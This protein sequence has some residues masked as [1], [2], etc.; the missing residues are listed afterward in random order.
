MSMLDAIDLVSKGNLM[1]RIELAFDPVSINFSEAWPSTSSV[2]ADDAQLTR[3]P[4]EGLAEK[5]GFFTGL[6]VRFEGL[7]MEVDLGF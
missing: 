7:R 6:E 3:N 5:L 2:A 1:D 4:F